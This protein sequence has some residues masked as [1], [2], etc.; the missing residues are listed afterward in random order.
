MKDDNIRILLIEDE[1]FDVNRVKQTISYYDSK[2]KIMDVVSNGRAA[3]ELIE[4]SS[5]QFDVIIL[6]YQISGGLKGEELIKRIK[7]IDPFIQI[8]VITKMTINITDYNFANN[9]L[10]AGAF[11][12]CTKYPG[13]IEDYI[14]Q[15]TD[16]ILSIF[17]AYEKK[18]LEKHKI[19]SDS[20]LNQNIQNLLES[21]KLIGLSKPMIQLKENIENM[22]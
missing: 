1:N 18:K 2:I 8:I 20:K 19:K 12:Y 7:A 16:F 9:L 11:W 4:N 5:D 17:N 14:Y 10:R 22:Q 21:K 15:P 13:N 3:L 6:D